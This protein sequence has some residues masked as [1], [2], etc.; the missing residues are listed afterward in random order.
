MCLGGAADASC[1]HML[2]LDCSE[3]LCV[4]PG[5]FPKLQVFIDDDQPFF[6]IL[7][8]LLCNSWLKKL[9]L[10]QVLLVLAMM[11]ISALLLPIACVLHLKFGESC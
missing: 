10:I 5:G 3:R 8:P 4:F 7:I 6:V 2:P 9:A 11:R 1:R